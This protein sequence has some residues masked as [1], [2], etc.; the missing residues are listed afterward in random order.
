MKVWR[1]ENWAHSLLLTQARETAARSFNHDV[2]FEAGA[3]AM[4]NA[5][6]ERCPKSEDI[7]LKLIQYQWGDL[8]LT[9]IADWFKEQIFGKE[10]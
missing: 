2:S 9:E 7:R 1:P 4:Y 3:D 6:Q 5:L 8:T 10:G